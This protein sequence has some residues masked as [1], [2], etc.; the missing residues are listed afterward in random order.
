MLGEQGIVH[1][2]KQP[3]LNI[4][5]KNSSSQYKIYKKVQKVQNVLIVHNHVSAKTKALLLEVIWSNKSG[6]WFVV[7][8]LYFMFTM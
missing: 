7:A 1:S 6:S 3:K 4:N 2:A 8:L 5:R